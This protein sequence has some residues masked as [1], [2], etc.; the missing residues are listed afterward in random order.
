MTPRSFTLA[1]ALL[2]V[3]AGIPA[4]WVPPAQAQ[5]PDHFDPSW[6][7]YRLQAELSGTRWLLL[8]PTDG[9]SAPEVQ[10]WEL[11]G[12]PY[13]AYPQRFEL[14]ITNLE[15]DSAGVYHATHVGTEQWGVMDGAVCWLMEQSSGKVPTFCFPYAPPAET[16]GPV[17]RTCLPRSDAARTCY[18]YRPGGAMIGADEGFSP[19]VQVEEDQGE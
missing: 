1:L 10:L 5:T 4:V 9:A 3:L 17:V 2:V 19:Y 7:D 6:S 11:E 12:E 13:G 8:E 16:V 14:T 18:R 15:A